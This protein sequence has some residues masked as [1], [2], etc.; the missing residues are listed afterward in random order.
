MAFKL[1]EVLAPYDVLVHE[2]RV[3]HFRGE[4]MHFEALRVNGEGGKKGSHASHAD[5][6]DIMLDVVEGEDLFR[7]IVEVIWLD[8]VI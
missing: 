8:R 1:F 4:L 3:G 7:K 2:I 5:G 6:L